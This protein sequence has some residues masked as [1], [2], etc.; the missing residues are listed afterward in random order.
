MLML[1]QEAFKESAKGLR[2]R[3][4]ADTRHSV[5]K[6]DLILGIESLWKVF[7]L[8]K[9]S[10]SSSPWTI[11]ACFVWVSHQ[12]LKLLLSFLSPSGQYP[13]LSLPL[14]ICSNF[15]LGV[16]PSGLRASALCVYLQVRLIR[17]VSR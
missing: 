3:I 6:V 13:C 15:A 9:E 11:V 7:L 8:A 17:C 10:F 5:R 12:G 16:Q 14:S 1:R 4:L 2:W